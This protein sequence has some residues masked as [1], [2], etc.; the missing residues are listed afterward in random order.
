MTD[1]LDADTKRQEKVKEDQMTQREADAEAEKWE[2]EE[3]KKRRGALQ[4]KV[5]TAFAKYHA[6]TLV[7]RFYEKIAANFYDNVRMDKLTMDAYNASLKVFAKGE[8]KS[9]TM[10]TMFHTTFWANMIAFMADY[11][12]HQA[13]LFY[14]YYIYIKDRRKKNDGSEEEGFNGALMTSMLK[15]STQL[16]ISRGFGLFC[17]SIGGAVGTVLWPGWGT[18]V[19]GNLGD[20]V[21]NL[22]LDDGTSTTVKK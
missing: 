4:N 14:G 11:S 15:K 20:S 22:I 9:Q 10:E 21:G 17:T 5:I 16:A 1:Q 2:K 8:S 3:W 7:M 6:V 18:I 19:A 13:I 12:V